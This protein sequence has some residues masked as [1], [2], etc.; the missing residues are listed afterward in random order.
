MQQLI[1]HD[2]TQELNGQIARIVN[3]SKSLKF[4]DADENQIRK[5]LSVIFLMIGLRP[6]HFPTEQETAF[7]IKHIKSEYGTKG[8]DDMILAFEL[9]VTHK[10]YI[11]DVNPYDQF[12]ILYL[13]NIME[14]Y[15][16]YRNHN[17]KSVQAPT[18]QLEVPKLS[19][20]DKLNEIEELRG[21]NNNINLFPLYIYEWLV[22][23]D[24]LKLSVEDKEKYYSRASD[25]YLNKLH[26]E[27]IL[28]G[29]FREY[30]AYNKMHQQ[31]FKMI[32]GDAVKMI[33]NIAKKMVAI[34]YLSNNL[35]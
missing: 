15:R 35:N 34:D 21:K 10:L 33:R 22:E 4:I 29:N 3:A 25:Y 32:K 6:Q 28:H 20:E 11:K 31:G 12:T 8:L 1:K 19:K 7:L 14:A 16:V 24:L 9:A 18:P 27:A 30:N 13:G 17:L 5:T 23:F 2:S 26:N